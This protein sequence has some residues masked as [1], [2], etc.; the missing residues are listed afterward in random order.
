MV[1]E[2]KL[3]AQ[4]TDKNIIFEGEIPQRGYWQGIEVRGGKA[5]FEDCVI[6]FAQDGVAC[7]GEKT[8]AEIVDSKIYE[9]SKRGV[10]LFSAYAYLL[11]NKISKNGEDGIRATNFAGIER[12]NVVGGIVGKNGR[13]GVSVSQFW[14]G[15]S[16]VIVEENLKNGIFTQNYFHPHGVSIRQCIIRNNLEYAVCGVF[17]TEVKKCE[18]YGNCSKLNIP[19]LQDP[20]KKN[21]DRACETQCEDGIWVE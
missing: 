2:G 16:G 19:K 13:N 4:G 12:I 18:I 15:I 14:M 1:V 3:I 9:N 6:R 5:Y 17:G 7:F 21:S 11:N 10:Y 20:G 8:R